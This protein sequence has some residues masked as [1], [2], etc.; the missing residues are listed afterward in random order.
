MADERTLQTDEELKEETVSEETE[1]EEE[2]DK[3]ETSEETE[4]ED[5]DS[6]T[7]TKAEHTKLIDENENNR[8]G[9]IRLNKELKDSKKPEKVEKTDD[10]VKKSD[11][12]KDNEKKAIKQA[13][14]PLDSDND[15]LKTIK[16]EIDENWDKIIPHYNKST[17]KEDVDAQVEAILDAH[18]AWK[19]R[20]PQSTDEEAEAKAEISQSAGT[21]GKSPKDTPSKKKSILP[22]DDGMKEWYN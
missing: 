16:I 13:T 4:T 12:Y 10:F 19:R 1:T 22:K 5:K 2:S 3:S 21:G 18:S 9:I 6:V 8:K 15:E 7:L 11:F 20:N 17:S 14:T